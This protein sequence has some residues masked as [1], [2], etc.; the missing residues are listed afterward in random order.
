MGQLNIFGGEDAGPTQ[1]E[2]PMVREYGAYSDTTK[3][4]KQCKFLWH[5]N[6]HSKSYIKCALRGTSRSS[7]TDHR[8]K[9]SACR[10]Y[11]E[12]KP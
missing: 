8:A 5:D 3:T 10:M 11:E 1:S 2:N 9:W 12:V 7:A 6:H 4:C